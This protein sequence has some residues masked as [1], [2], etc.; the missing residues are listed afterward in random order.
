MT[1]MASPVASRLLQHHLL[2]VGTDPISG[3]W[4]DGYR[5]VVHSTIAQYL[6]SHGTLPAISSQT[7]HDSACLAV[8]TVLVNSP[9]AVEAVLALTALRST[10][11]SAF[12]I[13]WHAAATENPVLRLSAFAAGANM[14]TCSTSS[15]QEAARRVLLLKGGGTICCPWCGLAGLTPQ[16]FWRHQPLYH[17]YH[18]HVG[19][20]CALHTGIVQEMTGG[21]Q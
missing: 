2:V 21:M 15:L 16:D 8:H 12:L 4:P 1:D 18:R 10:Y 5:S 13:L 9:D 11:P 14:V 3:S 20:G 19:A 17:I 6:S 7:H